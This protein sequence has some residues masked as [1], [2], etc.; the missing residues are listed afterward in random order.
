MQPAEHVAPTGV[1]SGHVAPRHLEVY[2]VLEDSASDQEAVVEGACSPS[3]CR[4][5]GCNAFYYG[6]FCSA[7]I[8]LALRVPPRETCALN[9]IICPQ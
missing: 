5:Y 8:P 6:W 7:K 3:S 9:V 2:P 4:D 1:A